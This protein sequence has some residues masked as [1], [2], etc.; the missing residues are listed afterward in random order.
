MMQTNTSRVKATVMKLEDGTKEPFC[1]RLRQARDRACGFLLTQQHDDGS[2]G[3]HERGVADC[4]KALMAFEVCGE[5][6]AATRLCRWIRQNGLLPTG[7]FGPRPSQSSNFSY[8]Y[9][10]A[11]II[12]G[13]CRLG[14][15]D[16]AH[17]GMQ[18]LLTFQ[19]RETGGFYSTAAEHGAE[20]KQDLW[21]IAA[22]GLAALATGK[23]G[24]ARRAGEWLRHM[25]D[26]Q[27]DFPRRLYLVYTRAQGLHFAP[28]PGDHQIRYVVESD[29]GSDQFFF[30]PGIAAAFLGQLFQATGEKRWIP[31]AKD[32][33]VLAEVA[34]EY[35]YGLLRAGKVG[36]GATILYQ[37]TGEIKYL[38]MARR[39][40]ETLLQLQGRSGAWAESTD[41]VIEFTCE[42][43]VWADIIQ[44]I[45]ANQKQR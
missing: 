43:V 11:W 12:W 34:S 14:Q 36:W 5:T 33:L 8:P 26:L 18:F 4:Y 6:R 2:L 25:F 39:V 13:A 30:A 40:G 32:Y 42:M 27:P 38:E 20:G 3:K 1:D 45:Y 28:D 24:V 31:L 37:V 29:S 10:N 44:Q 15:Y 17:R 21:V 41:E 19:D 9:L 23:M 7:D 35:L 22:C 16:L